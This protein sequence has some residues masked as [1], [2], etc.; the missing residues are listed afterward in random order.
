MTV[1]PRSGLSE[2]Q[3]TL[4]KTKLVAARRELAERQR[5]PVTEGSPAAFP[6]PGDPADQAELSFE[7]A[8]SVE[9]HE[10]DRRRQHEI[11]DA[12]ARMDD[13]RYGICEATGEPIGFDRLAAEPE[14]RYTRDYQSQLEAALG[15]NHPP[16]L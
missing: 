4:L 10:A 16:R 13:G 1:N 7:Q 3:V 8:I 6:D 12:L 9:R 15:I 14:T 2:Q 11:D 5:R